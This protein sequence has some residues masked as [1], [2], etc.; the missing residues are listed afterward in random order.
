MSQTIFYQTFSQLFVEKALIIILMSLY[1]ISNEHAFLTNCIICD[2]MTIE[3]TDQDVKSRCIKCNQYVNKTIYPRYNLRKPFDN[4]INIFSIMISSAEKY[5]IISTPS[6]DIDSNLQ[7]LNIDLK[8]NNLRSIV[9]FVIYI[10]CSDT[11]YAFS[12]MYIKP[13]VKLFAIINS[14]T[15]GYNLKNKLVRYDIDPTDCNNNTFRKFSI[16]MFETC[17]INYEL[18]N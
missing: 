11:T 2:N 9:A 6:S 1:S 8:Y 7:L 17:Y 12:I 16:K 18:M 13:L 14:Y 15:N 10:K 4:L 3:W 5:Y